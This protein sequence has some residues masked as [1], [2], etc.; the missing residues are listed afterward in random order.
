MDKSSH[1]STLFLY[2]NK[3]PTKHCNGKISH[4]KELILN[5]FQQ[6]DIIR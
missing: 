4:A 3:V 6:C 2:C 5:L 1:S